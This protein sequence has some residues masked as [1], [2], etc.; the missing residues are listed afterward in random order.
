M[1]EFGD[2]DILDIFNI[3]ENVE[4]ILMLFFFQFLALKYILIY[5]LM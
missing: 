1:G 3:S 4:N 5:E 2:I